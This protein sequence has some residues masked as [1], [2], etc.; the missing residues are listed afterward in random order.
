M[1]S[2]PSPVSLKRPGTMSTAEL[3]AWAQVGKN[4]VPQ[5]VTRFG[6]REITGNAKNHRFSVHDVL[7]KILG[8]S[9]QTAEDLERL[10]IPL[11]KA[12]WVSQMTGLSVS[13]ISA[14]VCEKR[15]SL[16]LPI[17][18]T[19]TGPDQAPA[20]GRRWIPAQIE[21]HLCGD[22]IPFLAPHATARKAT[23]KRVPEP[24]CNVFAAICGANAE[25]S[26]QLQS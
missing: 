12:S 9:P 4:L 1:I 2:L 14:S 3:A 16:P 23:P 26:R 19:T 20:R 22:P 13:A 11:Q 15:G 8:V 18:L 7:R 17:E 25:V 10:L 24:A 5:F 6:I 21:A